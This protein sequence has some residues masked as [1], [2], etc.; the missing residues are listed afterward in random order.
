ML[1]VA[2][3]FQRRLLQTDEVDVSKIAIGLRRGIV[4][5]MIA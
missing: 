5:V 2:H 1:L 4:L 3:G